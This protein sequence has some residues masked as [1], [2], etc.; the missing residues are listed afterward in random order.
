MKKLT[1]KLTKKAVENM[2][3][4]AFQ[5]HGYGIQIPMLNIGDIMRAGREAV[6]NGQDVD[7]AVKDAIEQCRV[8]E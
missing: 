6:L 8:K 3:D 2:V 7:T 1:K 4:A 5:R